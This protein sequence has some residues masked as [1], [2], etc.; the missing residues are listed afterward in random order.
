MGPAGPFREPLEMWSK[1]DSNSVRDPSA[2]S[3]AGGCTLPANVIGP[4]S[5]SVPLLVWTRTVSEPETD[6]AVSNCALTLTSQVPSLVV[7][8]RDDA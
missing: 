4:L 2:P 6:P 3:H 7:M 1:Q 8:G 5:Q